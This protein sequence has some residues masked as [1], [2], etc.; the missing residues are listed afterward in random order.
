MKRIRTDVLIGAIALCIAAGVVIAGNVHIKNSPRLTATDQGLTLQVCG[1]LTGLGNAD[2]TVTVNAT[3][4]PT[5]TC[6][7]PGGTQAPGQNPA[8]VNVSGVTQI[9][10]GA[11]K[12]GNV[13]F[14]VTTQPPAQ[15]TWDQAGCPNSNWT[16]QITD[17]TFT[18][19]TIT[20]VQS[21]QTSTFGPF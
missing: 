6:T 19:Y 11:I 10:Q 12:N 3:A 16:A 8:Q 13:S 21:G 17:L 7:N 20:V 18:S 1:A 14:C 5:A 15:P 2:L 9:P 4:T